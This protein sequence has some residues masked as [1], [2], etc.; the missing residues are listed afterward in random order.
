MLEVERL[1]VFQ[2]R[3]FIN[4][5]GTAKL[6]LAI[7]PLPKA[8]SILYSLSSPQ[9]PNSYQVHHSTRSL[10]DTQDPAGVIYFYHISILC[11][12]LQ[13]LHGDQKL[14]VWQ[15]GI[16]EAKASGGEYSILYYALTID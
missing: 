12:Y 1:L 9:C 7:S 6:N 10:I 15:L 2:A 11:C 8:H 4:D 5:A 3:K 14:D 16:T 13:D